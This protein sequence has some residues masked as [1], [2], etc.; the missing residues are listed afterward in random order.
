MKE[1]ILACICAATLLVPFF[2]CGGND[3]TDNIKANVNEW[4]ELTAFYTDGDA[5]YNTEVSGGVYRIN[6]SEILF[7]ETGK[8]ILTH[9]DDSKT[10]IEVADKIAPQIFVELKDFKPELNKA[11]ELPK[12]TVIDGY[13][14]K[15]NEYTLTVDGQTAREV[16]FT[17]Y[18]VKTLKITAVDRSGNKAEKTIDLECVPEVNVAVTAGTEITLGKDFFY[19]LD[20]TTYNFNFT[21]KEINGLT[22]AETLYANGFTVKSG[23]CYEVS[24]AARNTLGETVRQYK[25]FYDKNVKVM[26]F[27][28]IGNGNFLQNETDFYLQY[29]VFEKV[30]NG[31]KTE[32]AT[33]P[34]YSR[35][36]DGQNDGN[37]RL[38]ISSASGNIWAWRFALKGERRVGTLYFDLA[39]ERDDGEWLFEIIP[40][41]QIFY[42]DAGR[43]CVRMEASQSDISYRF[44][45]NGP[46]LTDNAVILDNILFVPD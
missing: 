42:N 44:G 10:E 1:K 15:I 37:G 5:F 35:V 33:S 36:I 29:S 45:V 38:T 23:C 13:D 19:G 18:G 43:Y 12:I 40:N 32:F 11:C 27:D 20:D 21:V 39:F 26:T 34:A 14:G 22:V 17:E 4:T 30:V 28:Y 41:E 46:K 9:A 6:G 16:T 8:Y 3:A 24:G 25:L 2:G 31:N 7:E